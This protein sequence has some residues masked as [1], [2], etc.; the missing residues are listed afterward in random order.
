M[1]FVHHMLSKQYLQLYRL[2]LVLLICERPIGKLR[3]LAS[4]DVIQER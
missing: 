1:D 2:I 3:D 4:V